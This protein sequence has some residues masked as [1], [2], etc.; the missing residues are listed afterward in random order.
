MPTTLAD[1]VAAFLSDMARVARLR[2]H[3]LR[4]YRYELTAAA[5]ALTAPLDQLTLTA[6]E[7]W[8]SRD[9][10]SAA[11]VARRTATLS[12]FFTWALRHQLCTTHPFAAREAT[13]TRPR[14]PRPIPAGDERTAIDTAIT[15]VP[16][17]YRHILILLRETG[18]RAGEALMLTISDVTLAPGWEGIR[19]RDPKNGTERIVVLGPTATPKT[20]RMLRAYLKTLRGQPPHVPLFRSPRGTRVSY[21]ALHYQWGRVCAAAGRV[22][23]QGKSRYTLHQLRHTRGSELVEH[24]HRMEI[25]QRVLGHRDPRSTQG[26]AALHDDQVRTALEQEGHA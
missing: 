25:V 15:M 16:P 24:G 13:H 1:H 20:L 26:Y 3:M 17:P 21:D 7:Q 10:V 22:D 18:M 4:A 2:P 8:V 9:A 5:A 14:L 19:V 23:A 12:R 6:L 11:T